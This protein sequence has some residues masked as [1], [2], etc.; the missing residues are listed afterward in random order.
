MMLAVQIT[1]AENKPRMIDRL[2]QQGAIEIEM[3]KG[4]WRMWER[5]DFDPMTSPQLVD[6]Y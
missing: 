1:N 5:V 6:N 4:E 2:K 3:A